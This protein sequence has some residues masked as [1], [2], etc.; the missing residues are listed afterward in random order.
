MQWLR[1][2]AL[3]S[4]SAVIAAG[5]GSANL[6]DGD[7]LGTNAAPLNP[8]SWSM[9]ELSGGYDPS[10]VLDGKGVPSVSLTQGV[11]NPRKDG[12]DVMPVLFSNDGRWRSRAGWTSE[13]IGFVPGFRDGDYHS[14]ALLGNAPQL[15]FSRR[16]KSERHPA[17]FLM[18]ATKGWRGWQTE[19]L[20]GDHGVY[21]AI[22]RVWGDTTW[23]VYQDPTAAQKRLRIATTAS[24]TWAKHGLSIPHSL[25]NSIDAAVTETKEGKPVL[26]VAT[27]TFS[28]SA[29]GDPA[30][31][32]F[33]NSLDGGATWEPVLHID[34]TGAMIGPQIAYSGPNPI[35]TYSELDAHRAKIAQSDDGGLSWKIETIATFD[36][37]PATGLAVDPRTGEPVV[38]IVG[39][40]HVAWKHYL[41]VARRDAK[42]NWSLEV[43]DSVD[44]ADGSMFWVNPRIAVTTEGTVAIAY[45]CERPD[46]MG[47]RF[48]WSDPTIIVKP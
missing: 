40:D 3:L 14:L 16:D 4:A 24:G 33:A 1:L 38:A 10:L 35:I 9:I 36:S 44:L 21:Q 22:Q 48:A 11:P 15:V 17:P 23:V 7:P 28:P 6:E 5:C 26:G 18:M 39:S 19:T 25:L 8:T 37:T 41:Y 47:V 30:G 32:R 20:D 45:T 29:E 31:L 42:G 2:G 27:T 13:G 43:V 34:D 12:P 46:G